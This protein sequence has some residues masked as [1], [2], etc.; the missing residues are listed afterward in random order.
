M[1]VMPMFPLG[2]VLLPGVV[3]PLHVF[4]PRYQQLVRDCVDAT[5]HEFGV[6]LIDRGSEVGGGDTRSDVGVVATM[7]QVAALDGG[8]FAVVTVGTR[9]FR[10]TSWLPDDPYP[11]A[12]VVEWP[13][14]P[15][16]VST[17]RL[18]ATAGR[19][20]R[21]A[22]L[23]VEMGDRSSVPEGE[24]TGEPSADSFLLAAISPFGPV[25]QYAA[26]CAPDPLAR[27]DVID[28]L[29]DDVEAGLRFR[30]G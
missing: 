2:T 26:L 7:L 1:A 6:V 22:G 14:G 24:L 9:R 19:A 27:L 8:R 10:V 25:D 23:A 17:E 11:R 15:V 18:E 30:L 3:L 13:D 5:E 16:E 20:R 21:C 28:R 29:L 4:E 12:D